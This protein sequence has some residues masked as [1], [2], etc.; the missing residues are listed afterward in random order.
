MCTTSIYFVY[1]LSL[2]NLFRFKVVENYLVRTL[3]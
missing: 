1:L 3:T 2:S